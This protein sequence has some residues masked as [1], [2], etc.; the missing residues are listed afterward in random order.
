MYIILNIQNEK[1]L[2]AI[3]YRSGYLL[4]GVGTHT[5]KSWNASINQSDPV[6]RTFLTVG[7]ASQAPNFVDDYY[8]AM[9]NL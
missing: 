3:Q 1:A 4:T 9:F 8:S 6:Q 7:D 5:C 2:F